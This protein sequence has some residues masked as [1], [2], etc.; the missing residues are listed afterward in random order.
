MQNKLLS[1]VKANEKNKYK[2][3]NCLVQISNAQG[4]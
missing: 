2:Q 3:T 4:I 1:F